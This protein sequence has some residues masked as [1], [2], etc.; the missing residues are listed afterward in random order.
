MLGV[1]MVGYLAGRWDAEPAAAKA[2]EAAALSDDSAKRIQ[3]VN[4]AMK[5]AA[6]SL[7][8][9]S[10]YVPATKSLN[11]YAILVGGLDVVADLESG[12]GVDPET[13]AALYAGDAT[14]EVQQH[15]GKDE[16]GQLTYKSN[17]VRLYSVSRL[18]RMLTQRK[19]N[20]GELRA[21]AAAAPQP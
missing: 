4:D 6:E 2:Q 15:L 10:R 11:T 20:T 9:E 18:Q 1:L 3:A 19:I 14:D 16:N 17:V 8:A 7:S 13:F 12:R 21:N 5:A